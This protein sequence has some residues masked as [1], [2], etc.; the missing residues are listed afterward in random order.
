MFSGNADNGKY[1]RKCNL[2]TTLNRSR[3]LYAMNY[4][5]PSEKPTDAKQE[6]SI[7]TVKDLSEALLSYRLK[8]ITDRERY[9]NTV[10][11][12]W[13]GS[14]NKGDKTRGNSKQKLSSWTL[15]WLRYPRRASK[16]RTETEEGI[17]KSRYFLLQ[18]AK[19]DLSLANSGKV[20]TNTPF[21]FDGRKGLGTRERSRLTMS[22]MAVNRNQS[23]L[24]TS[25]VKQGP[26]VDINDVSDHRSDICTV[27]SDT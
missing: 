18:R 17:S 15:E 21:S 3:K 11:N 27:T 9:E 19:T 8:Q 20:P 7:D 24:T 6:I 26:L 5:I 14:L 4:G 1:K 25:S 13:G 10:I 16:D 12:S 2:S 23:P 22:A